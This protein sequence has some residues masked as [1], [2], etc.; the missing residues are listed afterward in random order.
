MGTRDILLG[1]NPAIA[2]HPVPGGVAIPLGLLHATETRNKLWPFGPLARARLYLM[3]TYKIEPNV[4]KYSLIPNNESELCK[5]PYVHLT[6]FRMIEKQSATVT[7]S[8]C[9][10]L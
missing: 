7:T 10:V 2:Y 9:A 8:K 4:R 3:G 6:P 1:G 5:F